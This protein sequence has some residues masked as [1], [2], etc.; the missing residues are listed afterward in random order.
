MPSGYTMRGYAS[1]P[2]PIERRTS[3]VFYWDDGDRIHLEHVVMK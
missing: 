2:Q 3:V 1:T